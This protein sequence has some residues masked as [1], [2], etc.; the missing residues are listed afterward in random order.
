MK[1]IVLIFAFAV[2]SH[3]SNAQLIKESVSNIQD[4]ISE[5]TFGDETYKQEIKTR[6]TECLITLTVNDLDDDKIY[7][8]QFNIAD[9]NPQKLKFETKKNQVIVTGETIAN[10]DLIYSTEN[11]E[12]AKYVHEFNL[13][14]KDIESARAIVNTFKS[15]NSNCEEAQSNAKF[16]LKDSQQFMDGIT[17]LSTNLPKTVDVSEA[18]MSQRFDYEKNFLPVLTFEVK[19]NEKNEVVTYTFNISDI[20]QQSIIFDT[21][22]GNVFITGEVTGKNKYIAVEKN[23][24]RE[25]YSKDFQFYMQNIEDAR[26]FVAALQF[27]KQK[28]DDYIQSLGSPLANVTTI[29]DYLN[30]IN[31]KINKVTAGEKSVE[32]SLKKSDQKVPLVTLTVK[33][34]AG[35]AL[36]DYDFNLA[37][38]NESKVNFETVRNYI[39]INLSVSGGKKFIRVTENGSLKNYDDEIELNAGTIEE[40]RTL[41]EAFKKVVA[42]AKEEFNQQLSQ[43]DNMSESDLSQALFQN[44]KDVLVDDDSYLQKLTS[45]EQNACILIFDQKDVSKEKNYSYKFNLIDISAPSIKYETKGDEVLVEMETKNKKDLIEFSEDGTVKNF[46]KSLAIRSADLENARMTALILKKLA[47]KC[48]GLK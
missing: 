34:E 5:V 23:G 39:E 29:P 33:D 4:L 3:Q 40:A 36:T 27:L 9:I 13:Y 2:I 18:K 30:F 28:S 10:R 6:E 12:S 25:N 8:Y 11:G 31:Q 20:D 1:N 15:V 37:D 43:F 22:K 17:Y 47:E 24:I 19:D 38:I 46:E 48:P 42:M 44:I 16:V 7:A 45:D 14:A 26:K 21:N 35:S 32:Q 41:V